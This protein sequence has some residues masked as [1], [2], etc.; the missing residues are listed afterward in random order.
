MATS[1]E[2]L[3]ILKM[4]QEG[5][6]T[7]DQAAAIIETLEE[8]SQSQRQASRPEPPATPP[9]SKSSRWFH[10]RITD[11]GSG[12]TRVNVRLP[13][14]LVNAGIKMG[15]RFAPEVQGMDMEQLVEFINSGEVGQIVDVNN[16]EDGEHVEVY[17]E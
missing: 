4:V 5:K 15:A 12:R 9:A 17:I 14:S 6:I 2:R 10:V 16:E 7:A 1:E 13:V 8:S 3:K 11:S